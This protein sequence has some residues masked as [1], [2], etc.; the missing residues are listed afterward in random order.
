MFAAGLQ[1]RY[2]RRVA[3]ARAADN[4]VLNGFSAAIVIIS[5]ALATLSGC[6]A[7]R[8]ITTF[9]CDE[10]SKEKWSEL[11]SRD[12]DELFDFAEDMKDCGT[13]DGL[14]RAEVE[15]FL[16]KPDYREP[17]YMTWTWIVGIDYTGDNEVLIV[18]WK[19]ASEPEVEV[20]G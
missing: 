9:S 14:T 10:I 13:L 4:A 7:D 6:S 20:L 18:I 5:L 11:R 1:Y 12:D 16:G 17:K 8:I 19:G 2:V 3:R 15:N